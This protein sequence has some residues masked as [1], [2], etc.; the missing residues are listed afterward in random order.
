M[1]VDLVLTVAALL[2]QCLCDAFEANPVPPSECCYQLPGEPVMD[3]GVNENICCD[4]RAYVSVGDEWVSVNSF[5]E[6]DI[7]RQANSVCAPPSW[8]VDLRAGILRCVPVM[9]PTEGSAIT[10]DQWDAA[11]LQQAYDSQSLR[12]A[13]C[14]FRNAFVNLGSQYEGM[15]VVIGRMAGGQ[16]Q[17]GCSDRYMNFQF[18]IPS[19]CDGC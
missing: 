1:A 6:Q 16:P 12:Q 8:G 15:S 19:S 14:C 17:G 18:Q 11:F 5:P 4:G 3:F 7:V 2:K 9:G 10:C 13:A